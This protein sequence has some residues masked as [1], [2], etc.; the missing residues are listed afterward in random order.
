MWE[1][2]DTGGG[3]SRLLASLRGMVTVESNVVTAAVLLESD[4]VMVEIL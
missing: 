1:D 2:G 3:Q 4:P